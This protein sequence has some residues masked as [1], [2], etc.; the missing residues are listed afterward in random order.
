MVAV[1]ACGVGTS[2]AVLVGNSGLVRVIT[3]DLLVTYVDVPVAVVYLSMNV[4][5]GPS[6]CGLAMTDGSGWSKFDAL[7]FGALAWLVSW[8]GGHG[9]SNGIST[10]G[11]YA[12]GAVV[13]ATLVNFVPKGDLVVAEVTSCVSVALMISS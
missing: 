5:V 1:V 9:S 6:S 11:F 13:S 4:T 10:V 7:V 2:A 3:A 8:I 12:V